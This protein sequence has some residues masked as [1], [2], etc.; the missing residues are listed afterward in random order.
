MKI[1]TLLLLFCATHVFSQNLQDSRILK[2]SDKKRSIFIDR[3]IFY[4]G[5]FN[6]PLQNLI[7]V[8]NS[9][10]QTKEIER[11]VFDL[12]GNIPPKIYGMI[13]KEDKKLTID[14]F[15]TNIKSNVKSIKNARFVKEINFLNLDKNE[16][17]LELTFH[18][19]MT[20]DVFIL[21]NPARLVVDIKK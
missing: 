10:D 15:N 19:E 6:T 9:F 7:S 18:K 11:L 17:T 4:Y 1:L 5:S 8:R 13:N 20:F 12:D 16:L 14:F 21:N 3:G 2:I